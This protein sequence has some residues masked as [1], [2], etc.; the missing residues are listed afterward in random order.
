MN[1]WFPNI[2]TGSN[3]YKKGSKQDEPYD[4]LSPVPRQRARL[5]YREKRT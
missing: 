3:L 1:Q 2:G 5:G 4:C